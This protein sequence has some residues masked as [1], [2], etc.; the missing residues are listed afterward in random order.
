M[1]PPINIQIEDTLSAALINLMAS[2][3]SQ[4][5]LGDAMDEAMQY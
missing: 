5:G 3:E 4:K 1:I 2:R